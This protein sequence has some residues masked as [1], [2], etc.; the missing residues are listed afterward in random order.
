MLF[1]YRIS[2]RLYY[3]ILHLA[4]FF[5]PKAKQLLQGRKKDIPDFSNSKKLVWVHCAS[6]GEYEQAV[7]ILK[8]F[9]AL[10]E[11]KKVLVTFSSPSG[12]LNKKND[13]IGDY[14]YYLPL[15]RKSKMEEFIHRVNPEKVF[16]IKYE[17][18][19]N[20]LLALNKK[21][22]PVYSVSSVFRKN[23]YLFKWYGSWNLKIVANSITHFLVQDQ[24]SKI[25]LADN[26]ITN[27]SVVGD[28]RYDRAL[29]IVKNKKK[30]DIVPKFKGNN[31]L[32]VCGSTWPR[33]VE[34]ILH[35]SKANPNL[36]LII[37]PHELKHLEK[38]NF[39][40]RLSQARKE[41]I[42]LHKILIIDSIG[43]LSSLYQYADIAYIGGGFNKGIHNTLEAISFGIPVLFGPKYKKFIEAVSIIEQEIG[44]S[45]N[46]KEDLLEG[47]NHLIEQVLAD[48]IKLFCSKNSGAS[49]KIMDFLQA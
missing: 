44:I 27:V 47:Y 36:K 33:D 35:L 20:M 15:D 14:I 38:I 49:S 23:H 45:V 34:L 7:P 6:L 39:G 48:K 13:F 31:K 22:I 8:K 10:K 26:F 16:L 46:N 9:I 12:Y 4:S 25:N 29:D 5:N 1:L 21:S 11:Q 17:F 41:N 43:L 28:T 3:L 30:I 19:P 42:E 24:Q 37:A 2:L 40:I 32:I 18:W